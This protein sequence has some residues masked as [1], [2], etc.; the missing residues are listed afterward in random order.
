MF[1]RRRPLLRG[2]VVGGAAYQIGKNKA[3]NDAQQQQTATD[4]PADEQMDQQNAQAQ[5]SKGGQ[6]N[7]NLDKLTELQKLHENGVLT[8]EE[9]AKAKEKLIAQL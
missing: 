3:Q 1:G 7:S 5:G 4:Q 8:D 9:F 2:A 6:S